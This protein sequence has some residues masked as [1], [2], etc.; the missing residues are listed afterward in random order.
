M[1]TRLYMLIQSALDPPRA[2][3]WVVFYLSTK[4]IELNLFLSEILI[5]YHY[6][7]L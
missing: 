1:A 3:F 6:K 7:N 2:G 4:K 5:D